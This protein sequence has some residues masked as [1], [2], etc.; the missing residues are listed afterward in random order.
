MKVVV[1]YSSKQGLL[2]EYKKRNGIN[3]NETDIPADFFAEGDSLQTIQ[4]V[5]DAIACGHH[6][7][8]GMEADDLLAGRLQENRPDLVFNIAEGLWGDCRESYVPLICER[9][10]LPYSG[11]DPLT[12]ALCLNKARAK[13]ILSYHGIPTPDFRLIMS[14][15]SFDTEDF[16]YPAIVKP[17]AEGSSK[18]IFNDSVVFSPAEAR[19]RIRQKLEHYQQ[20][21]LIEKFL[22]GAEFTAALWGNGNDTE[23][24]P[25]VAINYQQLPA[26]AHPIYSYEA[27]WIWDTPEKP[28][29]IFQCPAPLSADLRRQIEKTALDA[30]RILNVRD[31]CRIDIRL[32]EQGLA[33]ILELNPLP[34]ILPD[35]QDNSCFPKAARTAGY[36]YPGMLQKVVQI[37]ARRNG[38]ST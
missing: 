30:Y 4:S 17:L 8:S 12:L 2:N 18:G 16:S 34:G 27:K 22:A 23:V 7:V 36:D 6:Q 25:L 13:E 5:I 10:G 1:A 14:A 9:M 15:H 38:L 24:L 3:M 35:P 11:S 19:Q 31:W 21:V 29:E 26:D 37:A 20:P 32:D 28:L 33:H